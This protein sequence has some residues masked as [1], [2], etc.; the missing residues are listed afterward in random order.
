LDINYLY[1]SALEG[2]KEAENKLF[3]HLYAR[4]NHF[5][6]QQIWNREDA[7]EVVQEALMAIGGEYKTVAIN[8]NFAA[9]A[10]RILDYRIMRYIEKRHRRNK[11]TSQISERVMGLSAG[12]INP[13]PTLKPKLLDCL[14]KI[15]KLNIR[16]AR[17][18][19]LYHQGYKTDEICNKLEITPTN[20]Y[21]IL[22]RG[23]SLLELCLETGRLE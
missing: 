19:N 20:L 17:V 4:F 11:I 18:L 15:S 23:R 10:Y 8:R 21:T 9:W 13:D 14:R 1:K 2:D 16:Y 7:E 6:G 5:A 12:T 22:S 3:N